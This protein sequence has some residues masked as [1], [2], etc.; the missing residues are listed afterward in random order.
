M[1]TWTVLGFLA[2]MLTTIGFIPQIVKGYRTKRMNDVSLTMPILL[3]VGM[4]LWFC[5][6]VILE[7][8][9][10]MLWNLIALG[11]NLIVI[12]LILRYRRNQSASTYEGKAA[13]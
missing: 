2:G 3:S 12:F 9:P 6:G 10:I 4:A 13:L 5:Y 11:L 7:D 8:I 1:E